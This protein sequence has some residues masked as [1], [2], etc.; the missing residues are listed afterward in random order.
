MVIFCDKFLLNSKM[1]MKIEHFCRECQ[2]ILTFLVMKLSI[3]RGTIIPTLYQ[4]LVIRNIN[5]RHIKI[6][7][8]FWCNKQ[9][10]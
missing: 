7:G 3:S 2:S 4:S 8:G 5:K 1:L 9:N 10:K 6:N